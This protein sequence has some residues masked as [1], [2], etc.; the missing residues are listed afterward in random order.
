VKLGRSRPIGRHPSMKLRNYRVTL[1]ALPTSVDY[2][3]AALD[4]LGDVLCNDQL[5]CCVISG[6]Y[7]VIGMATAN[8]GAEFHATPAQIVADYSTIGGYVPGDPSTDNGC[9]E[10]TALAYWAQNGLADGSK[11]TGWLAL[12]P[13]DQQEIKSA[14]YLFGNLYFGLELP[15]AWIAPFPSSNGYDWADGPA[16]PNNGHCVMGTGYNSQ[17]VQIDSWGLLG[18]LEWAAIADLCSAAKGGAI[19]SVVTPDVLAQGQ[20]SAPNGVAWDELVADFE[21]MGGV[22]G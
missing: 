10:A 16:D 20:Q 21:Q 14:L 5:G 12:N 11:L 7:H 13:A 2:S 18:T 6:M 22:A 15:D 4:V 9:D 1:P 17:G 8:A 3:T 19:Y